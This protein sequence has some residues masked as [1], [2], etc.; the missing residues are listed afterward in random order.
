M[1]N[2]SCAKEQYSGKMAQVER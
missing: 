2:H 1:R